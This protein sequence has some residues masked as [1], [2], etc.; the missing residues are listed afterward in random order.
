MSRARIP[1]KTKLAS[2]LRTM[3]VEED[4]KL[5]PFIDYETAKQMTEDQVI[6]LFHFDH[7]PKPKAFGGS[8]EH[9]NLVPRPILAHRIKTAKVDRPRIAKADRLS[10]KQEEFRRV[11][12]AKAGQGDAQPQPWR[13]RF[14]K[15]INGR[16]VLR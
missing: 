10:S 5:V 8:D 11:L 16:A 2:A 9:H 6:S 13:S 15:K 7:D 4:G 14:K 1:F 12:L 3:L